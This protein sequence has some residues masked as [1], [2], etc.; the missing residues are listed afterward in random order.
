MAAINA[1]NGIYTMRVSVLSL[2]LVIF[3]F[4]IILL[5]L[6]VFFSASS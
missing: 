1:L 3:C 4:Q 5:E 2:H 6:M